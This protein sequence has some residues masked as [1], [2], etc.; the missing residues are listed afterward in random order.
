MTIIISF[1]ESRPPWIVI[2]QLP[3]EGNGIYSPPLLNL[4]WPCDLFWL[5]MWGSGGRARSEHRPQKACRLP[6]TILEPSPP[7]I[8]PPCE[9][10]WAFLPENERLNRAKIS[11]P[12]GGHPRSPFP[13]NPG[14]PQMYEMSL[15]KT[16]KTTQL[17]P[18]H[19]RN[20]P[21]HELNNEEFCGVLPYSQEGDPKQPQ[22]LA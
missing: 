8:T 2:L 4:D 22:D 7:T 12:M 6:L 9:R 13:A 14:Y 3:P 19:S 5:R 1:S 15:V 18:A 10:T 11:H 17:C 16:R 20:P 21:N